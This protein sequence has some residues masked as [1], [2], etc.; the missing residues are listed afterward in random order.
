MRELEEHIVVGKVCQT[1]HLLRQL[2]GNP[3]QRLHHKPPLAVAQAKDVL[4]ELAHKRFIV[5]SLT[6]D[7][8]LALA[9]RLVGKRNTPEE[10]VGEV[11]LVERTC[12]VGRG[13]ERDVH[14]QNRVA[15]HTL[16]CGTQGTRTLAVVDVADGLAHLPVTATH[17]V[18]H[19]HLGQVQVLRA[20]AHLLQRHRVLDKGRIRQVG[21]RKPETHVRTF[22][23]LLV[24]PPRLH[25]PLPVHQLPV[26]RLIMLAKRPHDSLHEMRQLRLSHARRTNQMPHLATKFV[27]FVVRVHE[28]HILQ[29]SRKSRNRHRNKRFTHVF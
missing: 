27:V 29:M 5:G 15:R 20:P 7:A 23:L 24:R 11:F 10:T 13:T 25:L 21:R 28:L 4:V 18:R 1:S 14:T 22:G 2:V 8:P 26:L 12:S 9:T 16:G 3:V 19:L 17:L 6:R